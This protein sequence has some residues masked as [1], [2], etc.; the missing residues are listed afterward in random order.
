MRLGI[1]GGTFDPPH[2]GH[3]IVADDVAAALHLDRVLFVPTGTHPF[4]GGRVEA[5][6]EFRL[7]MIRAAIADSERFG[8]DERE[9]HR[10]GPSYTIDTIL[11][12]QSENRGVELFLLV[13][14]DILG[15]IQLWHRI[16]EIADHVQIVVMSRAEAN[17]VSSS[18]KLDLLRVAVTHVAMS[19]S[20]IRERVRSGRPFR[21]L[22][23]DPV[24]QIILR[25][26]LYRD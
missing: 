5:P 7:Q 21:Y 3:L 10:S 15:E 12:L 17:V 1:F 24:Y 23:P 2:V 26:S 22:V 13:G 4:K 25:H 19:S 11:E 9:V 20:G 8:V 18:V 16:E 14:A 6:A